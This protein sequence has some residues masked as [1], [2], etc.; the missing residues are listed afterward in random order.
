MLQEA[1]ALAATASK[2]TPD[3]DEATG[4]APKSAQDI[5]PLSILGEGGM[6]RVLLARQRSLQ[7]EV[8]VKLLKQ[9]AATAHSTGHLLS[10]AILAGSVEHPNSVPVHLLDR[11][12]HGLPRLVMKRV[13]GVSWAALIDEPA[14]SAWPQLLGSSDDRLAVHLSILNGVCNALH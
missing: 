14:H 7:R 11:D 12:E 1:A 5:E 3:S 4:A 2:P 8:A 10:G 6:G 13:E 9:E